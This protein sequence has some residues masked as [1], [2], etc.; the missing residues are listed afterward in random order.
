MMSNLELARGLVQQNQREG[1]DW[2]RFSQKYGQQTTDDYLD[3]LN[4][5]EPGREGFVG[6]LKEIPAGFGRGYEG[7]KSTM[8]GA[9]GLVAGG[10]GFEGVEDALMARAAEAQKSA[11][12]GGPSIERATDV[13]WDRPSE[14]L[15]FLSGGFGEAAPSA[16]EA[17]VS[18]GAG[19]GV[20]GLA[21]RAVVKSKVKDAVASII[22]N[23]RI[24]ETADEAIKRTFTEV[25]ALTGVGASSLGMNIGEIY[26]E[27]Y[28]Y[29]KLGQN[30]DD[31]I[32]ES[33]ARSLA[34]SFG[35]IAGALDFASAGTM[36]SQMIGV[37]KLVAKNYLTRLVKKLPEG[38]FME[39]ATEAAQEFVIMA[40]E[41]YG[42]GKE[43][44]WTPDELNRMIDAGVLG[45][46]GG[47]QF[48]AIGSVDLSGIGKKQIN[49]DDDDDLSEEQTFERETPPDF[50]PLGPSSGD[51]NPRGFKE[52]DKAQLGTQEV[53]IESIDEGEATISY[54]AIDS[55][56]KPYKI[57]EPA[58]LDL[59]S[60][61]F[62]ETEAETEETSS[63]P[64]KP[65]E[66]TKDTE[67]KDSGLLKQE[68]ST[69]NG[70]TYKLDSIKDADAFNTELKNIEDEYARR[71]G[72]NTPDGLITQGTTNHTKR[73]KEITGTEPSTQKGKKIIEI[74]KELGVLNDN[75]VYAKRTKLDDKLSDDKISH[76]KDVNIHKLK[77]WASNKIKLPVEDI[78]GTV[79]YQK[80]EGQKIQNDKFVDDEG[81]PHV[82]TIDSTDL[83]QGTIEVSGGS[84]EENETYTFY[85][86]ELSEWKKVPK[87]KKKAI[88]P[89]D[90][91]QGTPCPA[92][93]DTVFEL[94]EDSELANKAVSIDY[95]D[96][97][98]RTGT[99]SAIPVGGKRVSGHVGA[100]GM[101]KEAADKTMER[102]KA[103]DQM[104]TK[105]EVDGRIA[106]GFPDLRT[107]SSP[108]PS[109]VHKGKEM[110]IVRWGEPT[111]SDFKD[112]KVIPEKWVENGRKFGYSEEQIQEGLQR[113]QKTPNQQAQSD[114]D[115]KSANWR[116]N[117]YDEQDNPKEFDYSDDTSYY[118]FTEQDDG[119]FNQ[120]K[121]KPFTSLDEL[122]DFFIDLHQRGKKGD[123][124]VK[125]DGV[126]RVYIDKDDNDIVIGNVA[127]DIPEVEVE[128]PANLIETGEKN[129]LMG[130]LEQ[131]GVI[132][133]NFHLAFD[134]I[135]SSEGI[136]TE[137][138]GYELVTFN[139]NPAS[140][141]TKKLL[142]LRNEQGQFRIM[143]ATLNATKGRGN[144][145][146]VFDS[147]LE[148]KGGKP[149]A[150]K[151]KFRPLRNSKHTSGGKVNNKGMDTEGWSL[152]GAIEISKPNAT[153]V[154]ILIP[155]ADAWFD[156]AQLDKK[157]SK[158]GAKGLPIKDR[159]KS[160]DKLEKVMSQAQLAELQNEHARN[161]IKSFNRL[162]EYRKDFAASGEFGDELQELEGSTLQYGSIKLGEMTEADATLIAQEIQKRKDIVEKATNQTFKDRSSGTKFQMYL[163][164]K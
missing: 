33:K 10:L 64:T 122:L 103:E 9:G 31:Y 56:G 148:S 26:T 158:I 141:T 164:K 35:T 111:E 142:V 55:Q 4:A 13:R 54:D 102:L 44:T 144:I 7:L 3:R 42:K 51:L 76:A 71:S 85:G 36:L 154:D 72:L 107:E 90:N 98:G 132:D 43:L 128:P 108:V 6:G 5:P 83:E 119:T 14:V 86:T 101:T 81:N 93:D 73:F 88:P 66:P 22:K 131:G 16:I 136:A 39:G 65:T 121:R 79:D 60:R 134:K 109:G 40:A 146:K 41:K 63:E 127:W 135:V 118:V 156:D 163:I 130:K 50:K 25:G 110:Y 138:W 58:G 32:P 11:S 49:K 105:V 47:T 18:F 152:V 21:G 140:T 97:G 19:M 120:S 113:L 75:G 95:E 17:G 157:I 125:G 129:W 89:A 23:K 92:D 99:E 137:T 62:V 161:V 30:D 114:P 112:G 153:P 59:L 150:D 123:L 27:L 45:A 20:G 8:Y 149:L 124:G 116:E 52:G 100:R 12:D 70:V 96:I 77:L 53:K 78:Q 46:I 147:E 24:N 133:L 106:S 67:S 160:E 1:G 37:D 15:R 91:S 80:L 162:Q 84:L 117:I 69:Y 126:Y 94:L 34:L 145:I 139:L 74:M 143:T 68:E 38:V 48:A 159:T 61:P 115:P 29:T 155:D 87:T 104:T 2:D 57:T 28:Q 151:S 82:F